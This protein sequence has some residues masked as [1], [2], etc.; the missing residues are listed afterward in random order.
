M[1][2][3]I[4]EEDFFDIIIYSKY[5]ANTFGI[6]VHNYLS[7]PHMDLEIHPGKFFYGTHHNL[8]KFHKNSCPVKKMKFCKDCLDK[9][10]VKARYLDDIWYYPILNC[11]TLTRAL[12][13]HFP[14]SFQTVLITGIFTTFIIGIDKPFMF[15]I[16]TI[17]LIIL[18][19]Y[20]NSNYKFLADHCKHYYDK[21]RRLF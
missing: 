18:L 10:L 14:I 4:T 6:F 1:E 12:T 13:Q 2:T 17:L 16:T 8:G 15:I 7:I 5:I 9:L 19:L 21:K 20:N 3:D 11:E